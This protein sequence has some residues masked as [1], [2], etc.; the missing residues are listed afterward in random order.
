MQREE[1]IEARLLSRAV[2]QLI[3]DINEKGDSLYYHT[4]DSY[5]KTAIC[6]TPSLAYYKFLYLLIIQIAGY[7][8]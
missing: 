1:A 5:F 3:N 7:S 2:K 4:L 8:N 6:I